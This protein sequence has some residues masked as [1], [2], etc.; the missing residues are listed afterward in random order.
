MA[1]SEEDLKALKPGD[2]FVITV[3]GTLNAAGVYPYVVGAVMSG[4][5]CLF[6]DGG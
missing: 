6:L 5:Q 1:I 2:E 4:D 3:R